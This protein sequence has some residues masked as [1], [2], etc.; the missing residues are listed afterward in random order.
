LVDVRTPEELPE[1]IIGGARNIDFTASDFSQNISVLDK[2]RPYFVYCKSGKRS[3]S[4][5]AQMKEMG[6]KDLYTLEGGLINW[7]A[8]GFE[9]TTP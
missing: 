8:Q 6:F 2:D 9:T 5:V 3:A 4:A 7:K 1:G